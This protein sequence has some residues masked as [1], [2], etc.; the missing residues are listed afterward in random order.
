[1]ERLLG[2]ESD[3]A[4]VMVGKENGVAA[5]LKPHT[6]PYILDS[7]CC[8]HRAALACIHTKK[9]LES[10]NS[11]PSSIITSL[12]VYFQHSAKRLASLFLL[13]EL[14]E[15]PRLKPLPISQVRW[16]SMTNALKNVRGT[17]PALV[18]MLDE[19]RKSDVMAQ[20]ICT[21]LTS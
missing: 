17:L 20:G 16:L 10:G 7:H 2:F 12:Y 6:N 14:L 11:I 15:S 5:I 8:G 3:G 13:E 1:M 9:Q 18:R 4:P 21:A 19:E